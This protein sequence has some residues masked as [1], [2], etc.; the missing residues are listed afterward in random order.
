ML[1][2]HLCD[3]LGITH[4]ILNAPGAGLGAGLGAVQSSQPGRT[5]QLALKLY[6]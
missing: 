2:T 1:H 3:L 6:Y 4:P 5:I